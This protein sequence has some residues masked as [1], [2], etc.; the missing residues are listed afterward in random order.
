MCQALGWVPVMLTQLKPHNSSWGKNDCYFHFTNEETEAEREWKAWKEWHQDLRDQLVQLPIRCLNPL[1]GRVCLWL[2]GH[3]L[4]RPVSENTQPP[5]PIC[6][7]PGGSQL[8]SHCFWHSGLWPPREGPFFFLWTHHAARGILVPRP[9]IEPTP[10]AVEAW[11]LS[12]WTAREVP[13]TISY[14][15]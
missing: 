6:S 9:G 5:G 7:F 3:R 13:R 4:K 11:S 14:T 8:N 10:P 12:H 2:Q 1:Y 15:E